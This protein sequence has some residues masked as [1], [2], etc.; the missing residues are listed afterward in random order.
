MK[1][2]LTA[3]LLACIA[4]SGSA[5]TGLHV[6]DVFEGSLVPKQDIQQKSLLKG[7]V[8]AP[9]KLK[10]LHTVKFA[11]DSLLRERAE[12]LFTKDMKAHGDARRE[13]L[14]L[15]YRDGCLYYAIVQIADTPKGLHRYICYQCRRSGD[16]YGLTL[17]YME[18]AALLDD[19]R[20]MFKKK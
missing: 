7:S 9:Y 18:G 6:N 11:A 20:R 15:E 3:L 13:N 1:H 8:V 19:L 2:L 10:V 4:L 14:E 5:Q 12:A 16:G 17:V